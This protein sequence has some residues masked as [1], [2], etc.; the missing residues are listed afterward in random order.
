M[1]F[2]SL[3]KESVDVCESTEDLLSRIR[4]CNQ[5]Q[6]LDKCIVGSMDVKALYPSIDITFSV[7]KCEQL[8]CE[9]DTEFRLVD[10]DELGLFL[11]LTSTKEELEMKDIYRYCP[12]RPNKGRA[13]TL[14]SSG[15]NKSARKRWSGCTK[16]KEKPDSD[17]EI[18]RMVALAL[19]RLLEA[20]LNNHIF[21][22]ENKLYR[23]TK[24]GAIGVGIAGD[25]ANLFMVWWDRQIKKK[26]QDEGI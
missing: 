22:F 12:T 21:C 7:E 17:T 5:Q 10:V 24:G 20:T 15:T 23:Q 19:A 2:R 26:L 18:K 8:L 13:P 1:I 14:T 25:V 9:S 16:G 4:E 3:I 6:N 11:S